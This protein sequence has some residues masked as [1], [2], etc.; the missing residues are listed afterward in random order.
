V[1]WVISVQ[2]FMSLT[3]AFVQNERYFFCKMSN[4]SK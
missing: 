3:A 1:S 4:F 2:N